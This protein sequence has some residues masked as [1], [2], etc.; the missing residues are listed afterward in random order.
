METTFTRQSL[1]TNLA[2]PLGTKRTPKSLEEASG[3]TDFNQ[4]PYVCQ[5]LQFYFTAP[6]V[7]A[8]KISSWSPL[9]ASPYTVGC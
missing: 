5:F 9:V 6:N 2:A 3:V 1:A 4:K 8:A 7:T